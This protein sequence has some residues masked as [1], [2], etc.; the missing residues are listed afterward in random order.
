MVEVEHKGETY[1]VCC[2]DCAARFR[3]DP[4][5]WIRGLR[6]IEKTSAQ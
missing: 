1:Y 2:D 3:A 4:E 5:F 6:E